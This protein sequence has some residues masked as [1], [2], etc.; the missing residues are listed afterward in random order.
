MVHYEESY[1]HAKQK[2]S[3]RLVEIDKIFGLLENI[4]EEKEKEKIA[5]DYSLLESLKQQIEEQHTLFKEDPSKADKALLDDLNNRLIAEMT[6]VDRKVKTQF[7][8]ISVLKAKTQKITNLKKALE[9][10]RNAQNS[11]MD[12][13][14][15]KNK[16][17]VLSFN[18]TYRN[19]GLRNEKKENGKNE[20]LARRIF[21]E[22]E[23]IRNGEIRDDIEE[24]G[25]LAETEEGKTGSEAR[26]SVERSED[27][28][29]Y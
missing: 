7:E 21:F 22:Q 17:L 15:K 3:E 28:C 19:F 5:I 10:V 11:Q 9:S 20:N 1:P 26:G 29:W 13:L 14:N 23:S 24:V 25:L 12:K 6:K 27:E 2:K 8:R 16:E 18:S 4:I